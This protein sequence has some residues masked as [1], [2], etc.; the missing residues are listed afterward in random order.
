MFFKGFLYFITSSSFKTFFFLLN[1]NRLE[2]Q[3][4]KPATHSAA[5]PSYI[6]HCGKM[7]SVPEL[8]S[9]VMAFYVTKSVVTMQRQF[10]ERY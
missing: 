2:D 4:R 6:L 3:L 7:A 5:R 8:A 10:R 1:T 9:C